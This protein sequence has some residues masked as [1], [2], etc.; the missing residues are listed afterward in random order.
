MSSLLHLSQTMYLPSQENLRRVPSS[1][2][3]IATC[4]QYHGTPMASQTPAQVDDLARNI[5]NLQMDFR[6]E[7][8]RD[9]V[10]VVYPQ[11]VPPPASA[12]DFLLFVELMLSTLSI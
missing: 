7:F 8:K 12:F 11:M 9:F 5:T 1:I 10:P 2:V 6:S 4:L 3:S